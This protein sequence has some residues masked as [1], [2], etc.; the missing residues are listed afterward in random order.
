LT[1]TSPTHERSPEPSAHSAPHLV[2]VQARESAEVPQWD[3]YLAALQRFAA[4]E[5]HCHLPYRGTVEGLGLYSWAARQRVR[6]CRLS[7]NQ[8][9]RLEA[10]PGW[11]W[12]FRE[13]AWEAAFASLQRYASV[14]GHCRVPRRLAEDGFA[15]GAWTCKQRQRRSTMPECR[16]R[17][18]ESLPGWAWDARTS[19]WDDR[20]R[21]LSIFAH[22]HGHGRVPDGYRMDD[23]ELGAWVARQRLAQ[24]RGVLSPERAMRLESVP[25]WSWNPGD[26]SHRG[27]GDLPW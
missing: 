22:E 23:L 19:S 2:L 27:E 26:R 18:L 13:A 6:R 15:L 3:D 24:R 17:A 4:R 14:N 1:V 21:A 10:V 20:F 7:Q 9:T 5:G 12:N 11:T 25:G 8:R 16:R